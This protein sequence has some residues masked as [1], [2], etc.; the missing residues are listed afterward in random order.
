[1][2][3]VA[4]TPKFETIQITKLH[5]TFGAEIFGVD[6]SQPIPDEVF[7]KIP[8]AVAKGRTRATSRV[9]RLKNRQSY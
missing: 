6:I 3:G 8:A 1:M 9:R 2:S 7:Q 4:H 5:S